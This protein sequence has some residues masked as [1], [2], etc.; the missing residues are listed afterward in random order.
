MFN[1]ANMTGAKKKG[2]DDD[3]E[4]TF[5]QRLSILFYELKTSESRFSKESGIPYNS[6]RGYTTDA[7]SPTARFFSELS[8]RYHNINFHYLFTGRGKPLK[9][10]Q[11]E[12]NQDEK[13]NV[14]IQMIAQL[15]ADV[16]TLKRGTD[17]Q[18]AE[19]Q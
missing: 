11:E 15:T 10:S 4:L 16:A 13:L 18:S 8:E 6:I 2:D 12:V 19:N 14:L 7:A 3:G 9:D 17:L 1:Q 5:G